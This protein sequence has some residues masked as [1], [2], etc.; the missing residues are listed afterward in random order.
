M[1]CCWVGAS[2]DVS[3]S[4]YLQGVAAW[5]ARLHQLSDDRGK[6]LD[7][8]GRMWDQGLGAVVSILVLEWFRCSVRLVLELGFHF[9]MIL[10]MFMLYIR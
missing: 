2:L 1:C 7:D 6:D 4:A 5:H 10:H 9:Y 3:V 8:H